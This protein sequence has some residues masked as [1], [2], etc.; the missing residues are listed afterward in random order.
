MKN[1]KKEKVF[2]ESNVFVAIDSV[3]QNEFDAVIRKSKLAR[4]DWVEKVYKNT[5][6]NTIWVGNELEVSSLGDSVLRL[7]QHAN[8][9]G[10]E[11]K[12]YSSETLQNLKKELEESKSKEDRL[13][14]V[15]NLEVSITDNILLFAKHLNFGKIENTDSLSILKRKPLTIDI[16]ESFANAAMKKMVFEYLESIQPKQKEYHKLRLGLQKFVEKYSLSKE[17]VL[18]QNFKEDSVK[19]YQQAKKAL[20]LHQYISKND[21]EAKLIEALKEF[22]MD[23]GLTPDGIVG[24][25]TAD[26]LSKSPFEYYQNAAISLERWRWKPDWES[27]YLH[28]NIPEYQLTYYK[29]DTLQLT[30]NVVVGS[31]SNRTPEI[32]SKLSYLVAYPFW[33][34]PQSISIREIMVKAKKDS[35]YMHTNNYEVFSKKMEE[36][37]LNEM[38]W[39]TLNAKNFNFYIRQKGG[40]SNALGF[41]K[42]I[43]HNDYSIYFHDTP[44]KYHF[45]R[46][47]RNYSHGC[48]RVEKAMQLADT[49]LKI[50]RN[51]YNLDSV[52][53]YID[54][55]KEKKMLFTQK[56]P[57]YLQYITCAVNQNNRLIFYK[58][59]Y[60]Y[61][62]KIRKLLFK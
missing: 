3:F 55:K 1:E 43:F 26:A 45:N 19:A 40:S 37:P 48:I 10:L 17:K 32:Y 62:E 47:I 38:E 4:K 59:I 23:H 35:S 58:D 39:D 29:N 46:D 57:I 14:N 6:Y 41:V 13:E 21:S 34:V 11:P 15:L 44:T 24:K 9:Y 16:P 53:S 50:D 52:K 31:N 61:D 33:N 27:S 51:E 7:L 22:Q 18:V 56:T 5:N 12:D 28:V 36:I 42:F 25:N 60:G 8:Y 2:S 30:S 49:L 54:R 20:V